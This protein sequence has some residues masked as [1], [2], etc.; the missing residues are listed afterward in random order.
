M[1]D[2]VFDSAIS[3][4][5]QQEGG[6]K[7]SMDPDDPGNWTGGKVGSGELWGTKYGISAAA[8]PDIDIQRLNLP[9]AIA[10]YREHYWIPCGAERIAG[11]APDLA[12]RLFDLAVNCGTGTAGR[13]LQRAVNVVCT[14]EVPPQRRAKWRQVISTV[15]RRGTLRIDGIVGQISAAVIAACPY[16]RALMAA[17]RGE[18]Y[19]HYRGGNPL[20]I[21][22]WLER[23]GS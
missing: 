12:C 19:L 1:N 2:A 23:L 3:F 9:R 18:A 13:M 4:T 22:G 6:G 11:D 20:Y 17:L 14:G 7:M 8:F 16:K 21:P 10:L 5:L 15:L